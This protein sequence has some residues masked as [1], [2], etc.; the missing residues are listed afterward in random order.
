MIMDRIGDK[1]Q[2]NP[3]VKLEKDALYPLIDME[4]IK[5]GEKFVSEYELSPYTGQ[6]CSKFCDGDTIMARITPCLENGKIA[7]YKSEDKKAFGSTELFVFREIPD[8]SDNDYIYYLLSTDFMRNN[9][10]N[11][12]TGASGRQRAD[13]KFIS[14]TKWDFP[15]I[16]TQRKIGTILSAYDDLIEK[17][18][19]KIA[20]LQVQAQ[21]LYKEW[22]V[23]MRFPGHETAKFEAGLPEGWHISRMNKYCHVTDGTHDTPEPTDEGVPLITG[24]CIANGVIDFDAA[25]CIS[26]DDHEKIKKRSGLK[27]GDILFSNIGT[28]GNCCIVEYDRQF[29]VKNVIIFKPKTLTDSAYLYYWMTS[30]PMQDIFSVQTNGASQQFVGLT[31]MRRYKILIPEEKVLEAFGQIIRPILRQKHMLNKQNIDLTQ[32]RDLLLPRL[33]SGKLKVR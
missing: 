30:Q 32:Q 22:F 27:T 12:M 20:I 18:N 23:R 2:C 21:E 16:K 8:V 5:V 13:V 9:A 25:Y 24:R 33:M 31:F 10:A 11:S 6:S 26:I 19:R 1:I 17:N 4:K 3:A 14:R 28:V 7:Q 29:S 15:D